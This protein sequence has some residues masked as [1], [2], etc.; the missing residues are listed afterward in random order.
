M[1]FPEVNDFL[2]SLLGFQQ[3]FLAG[4]GI[5]VV[6]SVDFKFRQLVFVEI[7]GRKVKGLHSGKFV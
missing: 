5:L 7:S 6:G 3:D 1:L 2:A 4:D